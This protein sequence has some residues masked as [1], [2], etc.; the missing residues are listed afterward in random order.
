M[1][2]ATGVVNLQVLVSTVCLLP[3]PSLWPLPCLLLPVTTRNPA[4]TG[5][6]MYQISSPSTD[7]TQP[8]DPTPSL[9]PIASNRQSAT[10]NRQS[11]SPQDSFSSRGTQRPSM[12]RGCLAHTCSKESIQPWIEIVA[13]WPHQAG[14]RQM[15]LYNGRRIAHYR[16]RWRVA[17]VA[18][19]YQKSWFVISDLLGSPNP[20]VACDC[21]QP[22]GSLNRHSGCTSGWPILPFI[23]LLAVLF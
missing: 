7:K 8:R 18:Q 9:H 14:D 6:T 15:C 11:T 13:P 3:L 21:I 17:Y 1:V 2:L 10:G 23:R 16:V 12:C 19:S 22:I 20:V 5:S 4:W